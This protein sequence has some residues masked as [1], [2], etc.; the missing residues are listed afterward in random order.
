MKN[1]ILNTYLILSFCICIISSCGTKQTEK[2]A[3]AFSMSETMMEKCEFHKTEMADVK[4]EIRLFGKITAANNKM[5]QVYPIVSGIVKSINV[6]LGDYVKQG[7]VLASIQSREVA[8]FQK[9]KLDAVN[10]VAIAEKN[11]Q[12]AKDLFAG[13]LNSEKDVAAAET[14]LEKAKAEL[15]RI[16][17]IYSIYSLKGGSIFN[18][19]APIS[20]FVVAK[21]I[22]QNEQIK[23]DNSEPVFSIADIDEVWVLANVNESDIAKIQVGYDV[24]VNTL[25][26]P[27]T[28]FKGKID[29]IFNAIDPQTKSMK[30]RVKISNADLKLKPEMNCTVSVSFSENQ[31]M[32][33]VPSSSV[34]FD[35]S[36]YWVMVFKDKHNIETRRVEI[37]RQL[38]DLTYI[39]NGLTEGETVISKN[40]LLIYDAI[41]D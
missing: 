4:N 28:P 7:Q 26:F 1:K 36:K 10:D 41:N 35:K 25:A 16:N 22:N 40:G 27:D 11:L 33:T 31:K 18:V 24:T 20:G 14:E 8:S 38:G 34:I 15:A 21:K 6:E 37:Y 29:K 17:E 30:V 19:T 5:A 32:I 2:T 23:L 12:V 9:E 39:K 3:T 13:K